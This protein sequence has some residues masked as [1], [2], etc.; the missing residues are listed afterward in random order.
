MWATAEGT[1]YESRPVMFKR[2]ETKLGPEVTSTE[3]LTLLAILVLL[4]RF[5]A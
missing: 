4:L 5:A 1:L 3:L 2:L